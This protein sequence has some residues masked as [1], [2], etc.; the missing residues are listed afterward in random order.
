MT[1]RMKGDGPKLA[2]LVLY[3]YQRVLD[4][5]EKKKSYAILTESE[6]R[7][8]F[9]PMIKFTKK[10]VLLALKCNTVVVATF[11]HPAWRMMLFQRRFESDVR[12][13]TNLIQHKFNDRENLLKSLRPESPPPKAAELETNPSPS[14]PD[15]DGEAFNFYP[16]NPESPKINTEIKHYTNGDFPLDKKGCVLGWWKVSSFLS[17]LASLLSTANF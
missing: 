16:Q 11:L 1:K 12:R 4:S 2:I 15:S 6:L 5:L 17:F 3:E 14:D 8:M 7:P 10:Y 13:I 9:D